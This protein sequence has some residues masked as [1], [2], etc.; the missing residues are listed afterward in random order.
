MEFNFSLL[1]D[2]EL[3][4]F[5]LLVWTQDG[6]YHGNIS[7]NENIP[8]WFVAQETESKHTLGN[9]KMPVTMQARKGSFILGAKPGAVIYL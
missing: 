2:R 1:R 6:F 7:Q 3:P 5:F 4:F 8:T 9:L